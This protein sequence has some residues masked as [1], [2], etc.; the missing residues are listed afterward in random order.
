MGRRNSPASLSH[1]DTHAAQAPYRASISGQAEWDMDLPNPNLA[2][3]NRISPGGRLLMAF[4]L[5]ALRD[6]FVEGHVHQGAQVEPDGA[7]RAAPARPTPA[8]AC[9][10]VTLDAAIVQ[11]QAA[12]PAW[13]KLQKFPPE[14]LSTHDP[15]CTV[16][17][18]EALRDHFRATRAY[19]AANTALD[20]AI[21]PIVEECLASGD[22][23]QLSELIDRVPGS[24]RKAF[25]ADV[26]NCRM[27]PVEPSPAAVPYRARPRRH[28]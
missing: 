12:A 19:N 26:V 16:A 10:P 3:A 25:L 14:E 22:R 6:C 9:K 5:E 23:E 18:A 2:V 28:A 20:Q 11:Y 4:S 7:S 17:Q 13:K 1:W 15:L 21:K 27:P 24:V 8:P